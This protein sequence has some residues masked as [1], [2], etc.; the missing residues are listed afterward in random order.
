MPNLIIKRKKL[1][2]NFRNESTF[3]N[4]TQKAKSLNN[5]INYMKR[6]LIQQNAVQKKNNS[7]TKRSNINNYNNIQ[8]ENKKNQFLSRIKK[9]HSIAFKKRELFNN[10][11]NIS[12]IYPLKNKDNKSINYIEYN[13]KSRS[14]NDN[15]LLFGSNFYHEKSKNIKNEQGDYNNEQNYFENNKMINTLK[16][17]YSHNNYDNGY[18]IYHLKKSKSSLV[19]VCSNSVNTKMNKEIELYNEDNIGFNSEEEENDGMPYINSRK[20]LKN[21]NLVFNQNFIGMKNIKYNY[22]S[23][24]NCHKYCKKIGSNLNIQE[25]ASND[26]S[27]T[28]NNE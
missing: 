13:I 2:Y 19:N 22:S 10:S 27:S 18:D 24:N 17:C 3:N 15:L 12:R 4:Y 28:V 8:F 23:N 14:K 7:K 9:E 16:N 26:S 5:S 11:N 6:I 25:L 1:L 20:Y 21:G